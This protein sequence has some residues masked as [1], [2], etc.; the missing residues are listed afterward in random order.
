MWRHTMLKFTDQNALKTRAVKPKLWFHAPALCIWNLGSGSR[1][2]WP[3]EN[4][5]PSYY[6]KVQLACPTNFVCRTGTRMS[7]FGFTIQMFLALAPAIQNYLG[8]SST[9]L[10]K[11]HSLFKGVFSKFLG[12]FTLKSAPDAIDFNFIFL[13]TWNINLVR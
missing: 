11:T 12:S 3:I 9:A 7:G 5:K 13:K 2:I 8:S 10:L 1:M 4:W 6:L